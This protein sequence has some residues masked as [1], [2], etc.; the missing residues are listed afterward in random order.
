MNDQFLGNAQV[1]AEALDFAYSQADPAAQFQLKASRDAALEAL[2][3]ARRNLISSQVSVT[4][5]DQAEM[6]QIRAEIDGAADSQ[7]LISGAAKLVAAL[8]KHAAVA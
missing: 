2:A 4:S 7:A 5:H 6:K 8:A 1:A 3:A